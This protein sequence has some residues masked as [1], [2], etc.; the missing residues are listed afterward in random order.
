MT[1]IRWTRR[2]MVGLVTFAMFA[3]ACTAGGSS[4]AVQ[5]LNPSASHEPVTLQFWSDYSG[6]EWK[7]YSAVFTRFHELYPWITVNSVPHEGDEKV[8]KAITAGNPPDVALSFSPD[9]IGKF[10]SSGAFTN[11][12]PLIQQDGFD[13]TQ[14]PKVSLEMG[15]FNGVQCALP[16]LG[17]AYGLYYNKDMFAAAGIDGPPKTLSTLAAD[18]KKLTQRSSDGSINVAGYV[19]LNTFEQQYMASWNTSYDATWVNGDGSSAVASDPRWAQLMRFQKS[20][21]DY[22]GY[23]N[24]TR[25]VAGFGDEF[26]SS[27]A[28]EVGKVA[29][30]LD[31]EWRVSSITLDQ[32]NVDYATA[33]WPVDGAHKD[34]YGSGFIGGDIVAIPRGSPHPSE[35]WLLV[36]YL[37]TDTQALVYLTNTVRNIPVTETAIN[38][39]DIKPDPHFQPFLDIFNNP[40]SSRP[41]TVAAGYGYVDLM[42]SFYANYAAGKVPDLQAGLQKLAQ[43]IDNENSLG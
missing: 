12:N 17:D 42:D 27:N 40:M 28:F 7:E 22:Y 2:C 33:P 34:L 29:M 9:S 16:A 32:S 30:M 25:F 3:A 35:A 18:A 39:P 15:S 6:R 21:V 4:S 24:L 23:D 36:K 38:S 13:L 37:T 14:F 41:T 19:P 43:D 20:L 31:G 26:S 10:C 1:R 11:L 5:T 8:I